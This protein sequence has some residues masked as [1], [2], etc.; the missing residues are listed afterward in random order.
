MYRD[1]LLSYFT[2]LGKQWEDVV[3]YFSGINTTEWEITP[4]F[5]LCMK[6]WVQ[7]TDQDCLW[8]G[9]VSAVAI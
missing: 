3:E 8:V 7:C 2:K 5:E 9:K 1:I 4:H 6:S